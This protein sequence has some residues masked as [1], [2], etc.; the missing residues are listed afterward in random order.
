VICIECRN[1]THRGCRGG[2]WCCC[3]H[4][5]AVLLPEEVIEATVVEQTITLNVASASEPPAVIAAY[6]Q[7]GRQL[8]Q[9]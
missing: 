2:T 1:G 5:G 7:W 9:T 6:R 4:R 3:Q 8:R